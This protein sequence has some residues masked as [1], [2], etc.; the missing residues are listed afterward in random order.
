MQTIDEWVMWYKMKSFEE[1]PVTDRLNE[2]NY[3]D[4]L[5]YMIE[6]ED[7]YAEKEMTEFDKINQLFSYRRGFIVLAV[8][9]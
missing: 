2:S 9:F 1:K 8:N 3:T 7:L 5:S 6:L 4:M